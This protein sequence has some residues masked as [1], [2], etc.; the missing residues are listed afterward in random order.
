M[1]DREGL[2]PSK[3]P[4]GSF[5]LQMLLRGGISRWACGAAEGLETPPLGTRSLETI[6]FRFFRRTGE[7]VG[8][9]VDLYDGTGSHDTLK[10]L[11]SESDAAAGRTVTSFVPFAKSIVPIVDKAARRIEIDPPAGLLDMK[12]VVDASAASKPG[13]RGKQAAPRRKLTIPVG[14]R[15]KLGEAPAPDSDE[16]PA[17]H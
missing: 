17:A 10:I 2:S 3:C 1:S 14:S 11:R 5:P 4:S 12:T 13:V 9:V 6:S 15:K 16:P 7:L 8:T